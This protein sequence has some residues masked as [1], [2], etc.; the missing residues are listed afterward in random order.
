MKP[1]LAHSTADY[2]EAVKVTQL[3]SEMKP[4][5]STRC[6]MEEEW[7]STPP[8]AGSTRPSNSSSQGMEPVASATSTPTRK[9]LL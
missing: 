8:T 3:E 6:S 2:K 4:T 1:C 5:C 9:V 7:H